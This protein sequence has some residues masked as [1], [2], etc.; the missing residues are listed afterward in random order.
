MH[1]RRFLSSSRPS[2]LPQRVL[3]SIASRFT[4][5]AAVQ[6]VVELREYNVNPGH[7]A[8]YLKAT[9]EFADLRKALTPVRFFS[10]PET[11]GALT[12]ATH[13][14]YYEGGHTERDQKRAAVRDHPDWNRY[15]EIALPYLDGLQSNIYV[16]APLVSQLTGVTGLQDVSMLDQ[17]TAG[18]CILEFRRY[19]L[20][21]GYDTVPKFLEYYGAGLP[22]KLSAKGTDPTTSLVT[23]LY[24][25]VGRLNEVIE[26]WRHGNGTSA[27]EQSRGAARGAKEWR[28]A[29]ANIADL[30]LQFSSTIHKPTSFSPLK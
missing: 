18:D 28:T 26:I 15:L 13:A 29:I 25:D 3:Q 30:A 7:L 4:S 2:A 21:L 14:Y 22:S 1:S 17:G 9:A 27:M 8:A 5:S 23:L 6:P 24:S 10:L 16:E 20:K 11:G 19:H 12:M